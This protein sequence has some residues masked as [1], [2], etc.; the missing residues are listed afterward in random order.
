MIKKSLI[1]VSILFLS[2][3]YCQVNGEVFA[4]NRN[5]FYL[6]Y[7]PSITEDDTYKYQFSNIRLG[8]PPVKAHK[9]TFYTTVG[10]DYHHFNYDNPQFNDTIDEFYNLNL[11]VLIRYRL[12]EKWSINALA[13]PHII[14]NLKNNLKADDLHIN[15]ILFM[16]KMFKKEQ[17]SNFFSVS[18]GVGY[19]TLAGKTTVNP[20]VN[21]MAKINDKLSFVAGIPNTYIQYDINSKHSLKVLG[22]LNDFSATIN[23]PFY[24]TDNKTTQI[25]TAVSTKVS[26]GIEYN[27]WFYKNWGILARGVYSVYDEYKLWDNDDNTIYDFD[28]N[29]KPY[30]TFGIRH[31]LKK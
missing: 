14:S 18:L 27:Y 29:S 20:V 6:N 16:E 10:A 11:S 15:G 31:R 7:T 4:I 5:M 8:L 30:I 19:L 24:T 23:T 22:D 3:M 28:S 12:S 26:A 1:W 13:M 25:K 9:V 21:V 17:S 2:K